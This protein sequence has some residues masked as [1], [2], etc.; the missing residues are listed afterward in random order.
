MTE[1]C[2]LLRASVTW[3]DTALFPEGFSPLPQPPT[4][5]VH[6][7]VARSQNHVRLLLGQLVATTCCNSAGPVCPCRCCIQPFSG[8]PGYLPGFPVLAGLTK[9]ATAGGTILST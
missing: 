1:N 8:A 3:C 4:P 6:E 7:S 2:P 5:S 9:S